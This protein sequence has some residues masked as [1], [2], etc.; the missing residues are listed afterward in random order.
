[1]LVSLVVAVW[2]LWPRATGL[3]WG[4][5]AAFMVVGEF[6][7]LWGVPQW[8]MDLSPFTHSPMLPGPDAQLVGMV[9]LTVVA[10]ALLAG[11]SAAFRRRD[12]A[13]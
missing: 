2:G 12:L 9:W 11:G 3:V 4:A 5:Y 13:G 10:M 8:V 1:V 6:G 7:Q